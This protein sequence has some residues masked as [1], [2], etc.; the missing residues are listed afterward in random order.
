MAYGSDSSSDF[1]YPYPIRKPGN[2]AQGAAGK[3]VKGSAKAKG[4][5]KGAKV[6]KSVISKIGKKPGGNKP[7]A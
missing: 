2:P 3:P 6:K 1:P 7:A 4:K 5:A